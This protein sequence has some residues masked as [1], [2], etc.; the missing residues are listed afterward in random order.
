MKR[1]SLFTLLLFLVFVLCALFTVMTGS[2]VYENI[3]TGSDQIF[4][5]DTSISYIENKVRQADRAGQIS[6]R[7]I[8]GRSVLC[9]R[10]D[11]LS[12]DPDV[13][14]ETCIYSDGGWLKELFTSTDSG[15]TLADGI[16]IMECGEADFKIQTHTVNDRTIRLLEISIDGSEPSLLRLMSGEGAL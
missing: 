9:L 4:Y 1:S 12:Q 5:E 3:Q 15:L 7:E 2:R 8:E 10:D 13:S 16:D 11:S 6:V 14:Y